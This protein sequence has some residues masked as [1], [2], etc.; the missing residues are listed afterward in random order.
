MSMLTDDELAGMC[1]TVNDSLPDVFEQQRAT[2]TADGAGGRT[3]AWAT[4]AT[5]N[6]RLAPEPMPTAPEPVQGARPATVFRWQITLPAG[7]DVIARD[8]FVKDG[9]T[10]EV[11]GVGV[12]RSWELAVLV[13]CTEI[14]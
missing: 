4:I 2:S 1:A 5:L 7:T 8:R 10:F 6:G 14:T 3:E 9:R 13:Q 11:R 12:A